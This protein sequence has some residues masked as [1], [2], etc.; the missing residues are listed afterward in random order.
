MS[1]EELE[2]LRILRK[3]LYIFAS[4]LM[5]VEQKYQDD[6]SVR[7]A[8]AERGRLLQIAMEDVCKILEANAPV[9]PT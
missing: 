1:A 3:G 6:V 2:K 9:E 8:A 7:F 4:A 5:E